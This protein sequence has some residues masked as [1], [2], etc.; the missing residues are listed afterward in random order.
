MGYFLQ[1]QEIFVSIGDR[2]SQGRTLL[3]FI[4]NTQVQLGDSAGVERSLDEA[5]AIGRAIGVEILCQ[6]ADQIRAQLNP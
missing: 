1:A 4:V 3:M 5:T 6:V 2:Y